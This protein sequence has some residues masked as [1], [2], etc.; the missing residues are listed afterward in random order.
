MPEAHG[1]SA[2]NSPEIRTAASEDA[3]P[4]VN[5]WVPQYLFLLLKDLRL[6]TSAG[7][8]RHLAFQNRGR[9]GARRPGMIVR[10]SNDWQKILDA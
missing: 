3:A 9:L 7:R 8:R 1:L 2:A 5:G 4:G 10:S 6:A